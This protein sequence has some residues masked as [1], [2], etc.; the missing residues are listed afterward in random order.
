VR[1]R[2]GVWV[3]WVTL[4]VY[5]GCVIAGLLLHALNDPTAVGDQLFAGLI[6]G[7]A[8]RWER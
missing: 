2:T 6:W 1:D 5:W 7:F 4:A 3:A 8:Q